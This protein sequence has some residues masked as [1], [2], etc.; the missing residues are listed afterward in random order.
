MTKPG[1][2]KYI[3][4][5]SGVMV[6]GFLIVEAL[7]DGDFKVFLEAAKL[8]AAGKNPYHVWIFLSE[9]NFALYFYSPLW[10]MILIPFSYLPNFIPNFIWLMANT[11]FLY[12]IWILL[13]KYIDLQNLSKRQVSWLLFFTI[14][15]NIRFILYNFGMIQMTIF[16][17]WG[18]LESLR[19][20]KKKKFIPG[21]VLLALIINIKI[22]PVVLIPYLIY[23]RELKGVVST[24]VFSV[25]FLLLPGLMLGWKTNL[26][27][28][29]EW[30]SVI[31]PGNTEHLVESDLGVHSLTALI[32][33]LL[34]K[35]DGA[36]PYARNIFYLDLATTTMITNAVRLALILLT[37]WFL[38]WPPFKQVKSGLQ[39]IYELSYILLLIPLIFP[40]QQKYAFFLACPALFYVSYFIVCGF[41]PGSIILVGKRYIGAIVMLALSFLLMTLTTDSFIGR[42]LN[43]FTQHYKTITYGA[44]MLIFILILCPPVR[45]E[46][47]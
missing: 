46:K 35:T 28:L 5:L 9:G 24:L 21:G 12:R 2:K 18:A 15:L 29:S 44:T 39:E 36:L 38:R 25:L 23:R 27:M 45:V 41:Q 43:Q 32:P 20:F 30:W 16:I 7:G 37:V 14:I 31:D 11:W 8:V 10:A 47:R 1:I 42:N 19:L 4:C 34:T 13:A 33:S 40:H 26:F 3:L 22:L 17:L 6:L